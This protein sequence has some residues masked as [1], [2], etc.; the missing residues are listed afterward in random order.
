MKRILKL[1]MNLLEIIRSRKD[2]QKILYEHEELKKQEKEED[3]DDDNLEQYDSDLDKYFRSS[4]SER[5]DSEEA[6]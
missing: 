1:D 5:S 4:N 6:S 3:L 2:F